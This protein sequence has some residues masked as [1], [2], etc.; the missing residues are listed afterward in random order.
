MLT[1]NSY[2]KFKYM[3]YQP[4][5]GVN[6]PLIVVLHGSGEIGSD[7]GKL[8]KREP[9]LSL[10]SG[11]CA[12]DA[13]I[14]MPQL[15]KGTWGECK[16]DL[17]KLIDHVAEENGCDKGNISITGHSLG[18]NGAMDMLLAYPHDFRAASILSPCR[19]YGEKLIQLLHIPVW[20]L[21]G[22]KET[23]FKKYAQSMH[24]RLEKLCGTTRL[25]SVTGYGHPIQHT[26]TSDTY[27]M[28][29]WLTGFKTGRVIADVSKYQGAIDW[30]ALALNLAFT[31]IKASGLHA[32]GADPYYTR[33]VAGAV[34]HNVPFH[35]FHFLYCLTEAQ[36]K[37]DA[38]LFFDTVKAGG[39]WPL[40]W[41]LDCEA[42]WG[43]SNN[44]AAPIAGIF[45]D[46]LRRLTREQGPGE[47]RVAI[48]VAQEKYKAWAFDYGHFAYV[49]I[50]GYGEKFKPPMPCDIWQY[51]SKGALPGIP[52]NVDLNV[53]TGTK[54]LSF[55]TTGTEN[56]DTTDTDTDGGETEIANDY[57]KYI[58]STG[59]HYIS[60]S[61]GDENGNIKGGKAGDQSKKEWQLR[62]WYSRP[63]TCVL[64][65]PDIVVGTLLA[66]LGIDAA[67]NDKIGY[68]QGQRYTYQEQLKKVGWLP[69]KIVTACEEDCTAGV[70]A[71]VHAAAYL[72]DI[73]SLKKIPETSVRSSN[74]RKLYAAAGFQVLT[75][76]KYLKS[77]DY[78]LP[79]DI[80]LYDSHHGATNVT[81]GKKIRSGYTY[82][83]IIDH[84]DEYRGKTEPVAEGLRRGDK[85]D[86][87]KAMQLLLLKWDY[88]C[89]P[90]FGADGDFGSE[91]EQ[92]VKDFQAM[93]K[94]P[95]T[96]IYDAATEAA[97]KA[98][99]FGHVKIT[100]GSV[101]VRSAP[102]TSSRILGTVHKGDILLYQGMTEEA[103]GRP[104]YLI[105]HDNA[106]GWVSSKYAQLIE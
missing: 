25:T 67:L 35:V 30:D 63:W 51:T 89:L 48:Y 105:V 76:S 24:A 98:A 34:A 17:K 81:C 50:P 21:H 102:G 9:Y 29:D 96:G 82:Q 31:V 70:N 5:D 7:L 65:F 60:N 58:L 44:H 72:L 57:R 68:D 26:W 32:N 85:G 12:P 53:L 92:A 18:A 52:G 40:F 69:S 106:N 47:I 41:V 91:T 39:H 77:G 104:W 71:N 95:V 27:K 1:D 6:L 93:S 22:E 28:F 97:L 20:F 99:N 8:K 83:D 56:T 86:A 11:K 73:P 101:N 16:G 49:W 33:N 59:T 100:G 42:A 15:P 3:L 36:A 87:V 74:M 4:D 45:E 38:R 46:E 43:I 79:G 75:D 84:L 78:L 23:S 54:P 55:F 10:K 64:R 103:D 94:L 13:I 61:G 66:Q 90:K 62:S 19:D 80:L 14:L 88:A 2:G 37:R